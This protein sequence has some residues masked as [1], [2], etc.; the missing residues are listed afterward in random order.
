M[1][2]IFDFCS[3][4]T[5]MTPWSAGSS[6]RLFSNIIQIRGDTQIRRLVR[7]LS[8]YIEGIFFKIEQNTQ[9]FLVSPSLVAQLQTIFEVAVKKIIIFRV[10][11]IIWAHL[12]NMR[13]ESVHTENTRKE[14]VHV[15]RI[16]RVNLYVRGIYAE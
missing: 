9:L 14:S 11:K 1:H 16:L 5:Q 15:L 7:V 3:F 2:E 12:P 6:S 13:N 10:F 4:S 8:E